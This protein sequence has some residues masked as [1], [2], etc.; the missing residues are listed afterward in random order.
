MN[1]R[2]INTFI[3]RGA[4][5]SDKGLNTDEAERL[6][7]ALVKRDRDPGNDMRQCPECLHLQG[8][9]P[10][11]CGN[12]ERA[13]VG[14]DLPKDMVIRAQRCPGFRAVPGIQAEA[15]R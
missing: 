2:E 10:W 13:G 11:R 3:A 4:R 8:D 1:T 14:R 15:M 5:F 9:D 7:D 6:A 12:F